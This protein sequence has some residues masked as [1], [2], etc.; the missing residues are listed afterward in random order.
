MYTFAITNLEIE[1]LTTALIV[2]SVCIFVFALPTTFLVYK[3]RQ[4]L[5]LLTRRLANSSE[6]ETGMSHSY[7]L[8]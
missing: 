8:G 3:Y 1:V 4:L 6:E 5:N 2:V 7:I